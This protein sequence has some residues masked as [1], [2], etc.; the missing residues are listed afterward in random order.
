MLQVYST[1]GEL[2]GLLCQHVF[3]IIYYLLKAKLL[4]PIAYAVLAFVDF[5]QFGTLRLEHAPDFKH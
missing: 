4:Q 2:T 1:P 3:Q 5:A